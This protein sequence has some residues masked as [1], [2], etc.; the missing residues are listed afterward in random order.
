MDPS[1]LGGPEIIIL[2]ILLILG[3]WWFLAFLPGKIAITASAL[4]ASLSVTPE[5]PPVP[6]QKP[7]VERVQAPLV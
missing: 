7:L 6:S 1:P 3:L 5:P 4:L 2:I